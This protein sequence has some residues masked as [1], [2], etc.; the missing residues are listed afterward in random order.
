M[1]TARERDGRLQNSWT[2]APSP[3]RFDLDPLLSKLRLRGVT[4][5]AHPS[6]SQRL[7][8]PGRIAYT[9]HL[10]DLS[11]FDR[12]LHKLVTQQRNITSMQK[13][14]PRIAIPIHT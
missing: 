1:R 2:A 13:E 14:R 11:F 9:A 7:H 3:A 12:A 4:Q 6:P 5:S 8:A 10:V